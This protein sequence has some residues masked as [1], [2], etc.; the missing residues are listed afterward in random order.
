MGFRVSALGV[1]VSGLG[2]R[3]PDEE[4]LAQEPQRFTKGQELEQKNMVVL[5]YVRISLIRLDTI[6]LQQTVSDYTVVLDYLILYPIVSIVSYR[7]MSSYLVLSPIFL[8]ELA[9]KAR[10]DQL[11]ASMPRGSAQGSYLLTWF[12][13][14][15]TL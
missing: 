14:P 6:R 13:A 9:T 5:G 7:I 2:F 12:R 11:L 8:P 1:R 10:L 3:K 4:T 15:S